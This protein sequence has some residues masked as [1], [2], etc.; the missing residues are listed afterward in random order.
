MLPELGLEGNLETGE[1]SQAQPLDSQGCDCFPTT[2]ELHVWHTS[3]LVQ[4]LLARQDTNTFVEPIEFGRLFVEFEVVGDN[5]L[6][7]AVDVVDAEV[8]VEYSTED[9]EESNTTQNTKCSLER[10]ESN[11][12]GVVEFGQGS[13]HLEGE[14]REP[15]ADKSTES[16]SHRENKTY[17][18][19]GEFRDL[20]THVDIEETRFGEVVVRNL[21][22]VVNVV[23]GERQSDSFR[24]IHSSRVS[25]R[26][27]PRAFVVEE[28]DSRFLDDS[29]LAYWG[30]KTR[31]F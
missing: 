14:V 6:V 26:E 20:M 9:I 8:V 4:W 25:S 7:D 12:D 18:V 2:L 15:W 24:A 16:C 17:P 1:D 30:T 19:V 13:S 29:R 28:A 5:K 23:L 11:R 31:Y 22:S 10:R 3:E 27:K 21:E